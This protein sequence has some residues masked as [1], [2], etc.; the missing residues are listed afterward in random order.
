M[1]VFPPDEMEKLSNKD[2]SGTSLKRGEKET[3][4]MMLIQTMSC[5][6]SRPPGVMSTAAL[7]ISWGQRQSTAES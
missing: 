1:K 4:Q 7:S 5:V 6:L 2:D 3:S